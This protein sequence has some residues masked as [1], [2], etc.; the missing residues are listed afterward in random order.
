MK[1]EKI[2]IF[3]FALMMIGA[4][5]ADQL[6]GSVMAATGAVMLYV[7]QMGERYE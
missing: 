2:Q 3:A 7:M 1:R 5:G 4:A 6:I